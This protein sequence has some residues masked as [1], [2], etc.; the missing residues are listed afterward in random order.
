MKVCHRALLVSSLVVLGGCGTVTDPVDVTPEVYVGTADADPDAA[1]VFGQEWVDEAVTELTAFAVAEAF[2]AAL[3]DPERQEFSRED[4]AG[5]VIL[6]R[7]TPEAAQV[8]EA[9]VD[10]ALGGDPV[11]ADAVRALRYYGIDEPWT[12]PEDGQVVR[13]Q[14]I[15]DVEVDVDSAGGPGQE[16]LVVSFDHGSTLAFEEDGEGVIF[17]VEKEMTYVLTPAPEQEE[18]SWLITRYNGDFE[19]AASQ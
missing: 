3:L 18:P 8:W 15:T 13:S 16:L 7:L 11:A 4:L 12:L 17:E 14:E 19:V 6:D 5:D 9:L 10:D 2:P 1:A